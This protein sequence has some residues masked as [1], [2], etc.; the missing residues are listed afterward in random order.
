MACNSSLVKS[1]VLRASFFSKAD[2]ALVNASNSWISSLSLPAF[3][4]FSIFSIRLP[5][6]SKSAK[7]NSKFIISISRIGSTAPSTCIMSLL[8]KH[9][10]TSTKA[11]VSLIRD[12]N[13]LP[14]PS[15]WLAPFTRPAISVNSNAVGINL[16]GLY[17]SF[18]IYSL[19]SGTVTTPTF[20]SIVANG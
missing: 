17:K 15:P 11:S 2:L 16:S 6:L 10:T 3:T 1:T 13:L 20:G 19:S 8:S 12:K 18:N 4:F 5:I 7:T 14:N 9:L